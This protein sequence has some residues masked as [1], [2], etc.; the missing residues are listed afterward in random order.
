MLAAA[1][2]R[3]VD[4]CVH[5]G[6][7]AH[8][9]V[10]PDQV[11]QAPVQ[12][13]VPGRQV[14]P[15]AGPDRGR[16]VA[17]G[18]GDAGAEA[19]GRPVLRAVRPRVRHPGDAGRLDP[20]VPRPD[21]LERLLRPAGPGPAAVSVL[22][23]RPV[24]GSL[25]AGADR[26]DRGAIPGSWWIRSST[27]LEGDHR[28]V[29]QRLDGEMRGA[30]DAPGVRAGGEAPRPAGRGPAGHREPGDRAVAGRRH[31]RHRDGG[32]RS[33]GGI[34]GVLRP[35]WP[36]DG[37]SGGGWWTGSRTWMRRAWWRRSCA[38]C[39]WIARR[40]RPASWCRHGPTDQDL[41]EDG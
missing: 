11:P 23:H 18:P 21:L 13:P 26:G 33:G 9:R 19:Q 3:G 34:P 29:L 28:P 5:R 1:E 39:T 36:G 31:G 24:R 7:R 8:A 15:V 10:Q 4:R 27:F 16:E 12:R 14:L 35:S 40:S 22:R 17:A 30:A 25:R 41:L 38:S 2:S 32:G 37:T 6:G 20:G